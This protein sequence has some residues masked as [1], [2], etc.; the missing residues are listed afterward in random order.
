MLRGLIKKRWGG[1]IRELF[2]DSD[3]FQFELP[4]LDGAQKLA[5]LFSA[6][7]LIDLSYF[8]RSNR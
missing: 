7:L 6:I 1:A 8:E 3:A 2:T 5:T 4:Q